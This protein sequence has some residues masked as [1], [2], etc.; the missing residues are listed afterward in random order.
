[1]TRRTPVPDWPARDRVRWVQ[2]TEPDGLFGSGGV[3]AGW[4]DARKQM[5]ACGYDDWLRWLKDHEQFDPKV[6]PGERVTRDRVGEYIAAMQ[7]RCAP[8]TVLFSTRELYDALRAMAPEA[9]WTWLA[10]LCRILKSRARPVRDKV[11]RL[12]P[13]D[14]LAKLGERMMDE[15]EAAQASPRRRAVTYRDGLV[16]AFLAHRPVRLKNLAMM[17]L[18]QHLWRASGS[19]QV[20]FSAYETKSRRPYEAIFPSALAPRLERYLEVHRPVL[21]RG[22]Q[23][24][25]DAGTSPIHP[26]LDAVWLS[27]NGNPLPY[28][29]V[30]AQIFIRTRRAFGRG[31]YPH[32]FRDCAATSVA[33]NNPRHI[34]D[35]SLIL[36]HADHRTTQKHYNHARS[37]EASRRHAATL[38]QL[39]ETLKAKRDG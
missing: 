3:A 6:E 15:A 13:I 10:Q 34:G 11:S 27:E 9:D 36:G 19:W 8:C 2:A 14:E 24:G 35:A 25:D 16:I 21:M 20:I 18:G 22:R 32:A 28:A 5:V 39:R 7:D 23:T 26:Q 37:L 31:L 4:S 29:A 33:V 17:R 38:S 1:M 12:K 30:A